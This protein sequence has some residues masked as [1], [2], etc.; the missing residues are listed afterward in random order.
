MKAQI[1]STGLKSALEPETKDK[2][3]GLLSQAR[4]ILAEKAEIYGGKLKLKNHFIYSSLKKGFFL[5]SYF[6][7]ASTNQLA[8]RW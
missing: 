5:L 7:I 1:Q 6:I 3:I 4:H 8:R 2:L